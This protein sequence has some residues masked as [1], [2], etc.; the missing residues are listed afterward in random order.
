[1]DPLRPALGKV[2]LLLIL[3]GRGLGELPYQAQVGVADY[4]DSK[5]SALKASDMFSAYLFLAPL[6]YAWPG[7]PLGQDMHVS[8][9]LLV[10][11]V[12]ALGDT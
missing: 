5:I 3:P 2:R 4:S 8:Y 6:S 1:M 10:A 12:G 11:E 9:S 7:E